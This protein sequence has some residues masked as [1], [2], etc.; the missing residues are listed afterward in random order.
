MKFIALAAAILITAPLIRAQAPAGEPAPE[1]KAKVKGVKMAEQQ[2]PMFN[3]SNVRDKR[4]RP[5]NWIEVDVEFEIDLPQKAGGNKGTYPSLTVNIYLALNHKDTE[6][7]RTVLEGSLDLVNV[8]A[9][10][11]CHALAYVSPA[12]MKLIFQKDNI[13]V[14]TDVQGFGVE[15]IAEGQRIAGESKPVSGP[16]WESSDQLSIQQGAIL[17]KSQTPF[18]AL[19][20]D[21]DVPVRPK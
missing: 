6:G 3:V 17:H 7:K 8:P 2:T 9:G 16:W 11:E 1:I 5:K 4:W 13:L 19:W 21:Y 20:G 10:E 15:V 12:T 18:A 14:S